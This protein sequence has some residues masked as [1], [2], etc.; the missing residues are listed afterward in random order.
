MDTFCPKCNYRRKPTDEVP[1]WQC[2]SCGVAYAKISNGT[3]GASSVANSAAAGKR[4]PQAR[5]DDSLIKLT[6]MKKMLAVLLIGFIVLAGLYL[7][8]PTIAASPPE[9]LDQMM[10]RAI[11]AELE[12]L[13]E[14]SLRNAKIEH[15]RDAKTYLIKPDVGASPIIL[16]YGVGNSE[17]DKIESAAKSMFLNTPGFTSVTVEFFKQEGLA[18]NPS[19][20]EGEGAQQPF[21]KMTISRKTGAPNTTDNPVPFEAKSFTECVAKNSVPECLPGG[22]VPKSHQ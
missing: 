7:R 9:T 8:K 22:A 17:I 16:I 4:V 5:A 21:R 1:E 14:G 11:G 18:S 19:T 20:Q 6:R 2:P 12:R 13:T 15:Q 10:A 3:S